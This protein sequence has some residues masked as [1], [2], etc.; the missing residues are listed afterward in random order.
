MGLTDRSVKQELCEIHC[1]SKLARLN[2]E[3]HPHEI[4]RFLVQRRRRRWHVVRP[5]LLG[6]VRWTAVGLLLVVVLFQVVGRFHVGV[7]SLM[8]VVEA[9]VPRKLGLL[10]ELQ[11]YTLAMHVG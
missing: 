11:G 9:V 4:L 3:T 1:Q 8:R 5:R 10:T 2:S 6:F 7:L